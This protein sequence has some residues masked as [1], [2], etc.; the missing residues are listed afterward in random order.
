MSGLLPDLAS[1]ALRGQPAAAPPDDDTSPDDDNTTNTEQQ[2]PQD[3]LTPQELR[4]QRVQ[5]MDLLRQERLEQQ[6]QEAASDETPS[7]KDKNN[8]NKNN[9][10]QGGGGVEPMNVDT[11]TTTSSNS[12]PV[13]DSSSSSLLLS[14][15]KKRRSEK[16]ASSNEARKFQRKKQVLVRKVLGLVLVDA[17]S[18]SSSNH[19]TRS[20]SSSME[21]MTTMEVEDASDISVQTIAEVLSNRVAAAASPDESSS[22]SSS[23]SHSK[24]SLLAY[25]AECFRLAADELKTLAGSSSSSSTTTKATVQQQQTAELTELLQEIQKQVVSYA[26]TIL[27]EPTLF[28]QGQ[29]SM[30]Q[31]SDCLLLGTTTTTTMDVTRSITF[32]SPSFYHLLVDELQAQDPAALQTVVTQLVDSYQAAL[33]ECD[34]VLDHKA[35]PSLLTTTTTTNNATTSNVRRETSPLAIVSALTSLC[36]HKKVAELVAQSPSFLLP[37]ASSPQAQEKVRPPAPPP[38]V[39]PTPPTGTGGAGTTNRL[40]QQFMTHLAQQQQQQSQTPPYC[41]RSGPGLE[42]GTL[43]GSCLRLGIPTKHNPAF[44]PSTIVRQSFAV[45]ES[46]TSQQRQQLNVYQQACQALVQTFIKA[47]P[48]SRQCVLDWFTDALLVNVGASATRPDPTKVSSASLLLNLSASLLHLCQPFVS[49]P[50]KHGLID[51]LFCADPAAHKG[52]YATTGDNA[53]PRLSSSSSS[54]TETDD[55]TTAMAVEYQPK[56]AFVT[57]LFFLTARAIH[58]GLSAQLS[59]HESLLRHLSHLHWHITS[60]GSATDWQTDPQFALYVSRQRSAEVALLAD[61][62]VASHLHFLQLQAKLVCTASQDV[63]A[64]WPEELV[65]D[66]CHVVT[67]LAKLKP[68]LLRGIDMT[69]T[70]QQVVKLL[71]PTYATVRL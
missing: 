27:V 37:P 63:V 17:A 24:K 61:D 20:S 49:N 71:S 38:P 12:K 46:A 1:W 36:L 39:L 19:N 47:G 9:N 64:Q 22:S 35:L 57:Q 53:V 5:R 34:S 23:S 42:H 10:P 60:R 65:S 25:L 51:P 40:L 14:Q 55:D 4:A 68:K 41:K 26:A 44:S 54:S 50:A 48:T 16:E 8:N 45:S 33:K 13:A 67:L 32:G 43:M 31:L 29:D 11:P 70:F 21:W 6:Q 58:L 28:E 56:N 15:K 30:A 2:S 18:T 66:V 3:A 52:L 7:A 59:Q 69:Y 62:F